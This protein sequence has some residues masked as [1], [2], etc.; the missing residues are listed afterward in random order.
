M[1]LSHL[2]LAA[3][4][5]LLASGF[6]FAIARLMDFSLLSSMFAGAMN[7]N[8]SVEFFIADAIG[9]WRRDL[10]TIRQVAAIGTSTFLAEGASFK[11]RDG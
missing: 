1:V 4:L 6:R 7:P 10:V 5:P 3:K 9:R 11:T 8:R 2:L